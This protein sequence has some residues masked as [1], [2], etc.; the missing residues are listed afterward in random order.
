MPSADSSPVARVEHRGAEP[1]Q[2][3][4]RAGIGDRD[5]DPRRGAVSRA[6]MR[7]PAAAF[8]RCDEVRLEQLEL[9]RLTLDAILGLFGRD[10]PVLDDEADPTRPK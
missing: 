9:A 10:V 3:L 2:L 7:R 4:G 6:V 8:Q 1:D 5:E